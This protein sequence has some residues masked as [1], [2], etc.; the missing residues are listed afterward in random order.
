MPFFPFRFL[1][2]S[3]AL[4]IRLNLSLKYIFYFTGFL[5]LT[6]ASSSSSPWVLQTLPSAADPSFALVSLSLERL[7]HKAALVLFDQRILS[8]SV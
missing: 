4:K 7:I 6:E 1:T 2:V 3:T 8:S 5:G